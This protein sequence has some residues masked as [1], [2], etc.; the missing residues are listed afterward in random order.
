MHLINNIKKEDDINQIIKL[1]ET[2]NQNKKLKDFIDF[3][4]EINYKYL[5]TPFIL[6]LVEATKNIRNNSIY[7][8]LI[9]YF[10]K[11]SNL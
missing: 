10:F 4:Y 1:L 7:Y 9:E 11:E 6:L 3:K 2:S 5:V 8:P